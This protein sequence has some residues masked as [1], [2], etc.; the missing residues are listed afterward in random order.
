MVDS[1]SQALLGQILELADTACQA[2]LELLEYQLAGE[3]DAATAFGTQSFSC[4]YI[5]RDIGQYEDCVS[6]LAAVRDRLMPGG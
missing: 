1:T 5:G 4:A 2:G 6:L 3:T